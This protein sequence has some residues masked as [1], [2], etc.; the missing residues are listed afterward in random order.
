MGRHA[1]MVTMLR[2]FTLLFVLCLVGCTPGAESETTTSDVPTS[3]TS[4][5]TTSPAP[6]P[7]TTT[8]TST[9]IPID[10]GAVVLGLFG[11]DVPDRVV[12]AVPGGFQVWDQGRVQ[13]VSHPLADNAFQIEGDFVALT[14]FDASR[15]TTA[16]VVGLFDLEVA[17]PID[18]ARLMT[19]GDEILALNQCGQNQ[20]S[21]VELPSGEERELPVP[22]EPRQDG[23]YDW[24]AER[25]STV[26]VGLG[27]AEGNLVRLTT[28]DGTDLLGDG[29]AGLAALSTDGGYLAYVDHADPAA[30]SHFWSPVLVVVDTANGEEVGRWALDSP[31]SC[32][33]FAVTWVVACEVEDHLVLDP[34]HDALVAIE[35]ESGVV[36][37]VE[38]TARVFLPAG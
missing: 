13:E 34:A 36:N 26:I 32:L 33:E 19:R 28:L 35:V 10:P 11:D 4:P 9:T 6:P 21:L 14:G 37:R 17:Y 30:L 24:F 1:Y 22:L 25:G 16:P 12:V 7:A 18:C 38:T 27:D 20:W 31:I 3:M 29:Y 2:A 15:P 8:T 5:A 23:E